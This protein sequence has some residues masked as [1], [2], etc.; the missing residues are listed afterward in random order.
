MRPKSIATEASK[1]HAVQHRLAGVT[2]AAALHN[3]TKMSVFRNKMAA[4]VSKSAFRIH[5]P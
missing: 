3:Q 5:Q 4:A 1:I 2:A